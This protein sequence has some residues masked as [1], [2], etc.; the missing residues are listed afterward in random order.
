MN[1]VISALAGCSYEVSV[2]LLNFGFL[3]LAVYWLTTP[4]RRVPARV[5]HFETPDHSK[6]AIKC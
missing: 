2:G 4:V 5:N 3:L 1:G 6:L